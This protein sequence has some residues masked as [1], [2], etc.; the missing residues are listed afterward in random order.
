[1]L[2]WSRE[3]EINHPGK[4]H[5]KESVGFVM[6]ELEKGLRVVLSHCH[7]HPIEC[8]CDDDQIIIVQGVFLTPP[9]LKILSASR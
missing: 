9:P 4:W 6:N 1:M 5:M 8:H 2:L 7:H 3:G